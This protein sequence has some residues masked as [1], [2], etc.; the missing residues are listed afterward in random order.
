MNVFDI[1]VLAAFLFNLAVPLLK[2][3]KIMLFDTKKTQED[4]RK[5]KAQSLLSFALSLI[6]WA[7][8]F[9]YL[10]TIGVYSGLSGDSGTIRMT[11]FMFKLTSI[12]LLFNFLI[13]IAETLYY[14]A[15]DMSKYGDKKKRLATRYFNKS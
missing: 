8:V 11:T 3:Y 12:F 15:I 1:V 4:L 14:N 10:M 9:G 7:L 2:V 6:C 13:T 5:D